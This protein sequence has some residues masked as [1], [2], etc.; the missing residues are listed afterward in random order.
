M[1]QELARSLGLTVFLVTLAVKARA[2]KAVTGS[3]GMIGQIGVAVG[4][5]APE[6]HIMVRGEYWYA[7]S[8]VPLQSGARVRVTAIDRLKLAVEPADT[9]MRG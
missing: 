7:I 6:G 5:L 4:D 2:N 1:V 9:S 3:E 8:P